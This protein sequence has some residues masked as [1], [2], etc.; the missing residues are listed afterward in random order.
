[1]YQCLSPLTLWVRIPL[2][3]CVLDTTLCN[4]VSMTCGRPVGFFLGSTNK[5]N[6]HD[7]AEILFKMRL[8][9]ITKTPFPLI[10][11]ILLFGISGN[12]ILLCYHVSFEIQHFICRIICAIPYSSIMLM[13][14]TEYILD[15]YQKHALMRCFCNTYIFWGTRIWLDIAYHNFNITSKSIVYHKTKTG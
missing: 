11:I 14:L 9:S 10:W 2:R 6:C 15:V 8:N 7:I 1:M 4:S 5:A 12:L 3:R 13:L